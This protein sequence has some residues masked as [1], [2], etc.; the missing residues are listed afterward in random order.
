MNVYHLALVSLTPQISL[1]DLTLTAA[2]LQ[3]QITRD[4]G[5]IWNLD[6]TISAFPDM[7]S[8]PVGYWPI[9]ISA[10][11][12]IDQD[13]D[14]GYH[15]SDTANLPFAII[16]FDPTWQLTCSHEMC[17]MLV[18]PYGYKTITSDCIPPGLGRVNYLVEVCD[19]CEDAPFAYSVNGITLSDF[20][21]P[22]YF[23]PVSSPATRYSFSGAI[24]A[25]KQ[26]LKNGYLT[27]NDPATG[28]WLQ[29]NYFYNEIQINDITAQMQGR[30]GP[31][32]SRVDRITKNAGK[33]SS[34]RNAMEKREF[35]Q[36]AFAESAQ[37]YQDSLI[38]EIGKFITNAGA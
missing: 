15:W 32:R 37:G 6:A 38:A 24:T 34:F 1:S 17:E 28:K 27:W 9:T 33:L 36:Q 13:N 18:D 26:V 23:D 10:D 21:T 11:A 35:R 5:P 31:I 3:K 12:Q 25:P 2:A 4:L 22:N 19:P 14:E 20:Y 7:K 30:K 8:V 16:K 29:A